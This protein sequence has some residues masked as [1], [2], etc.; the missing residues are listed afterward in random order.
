MAKFE[1]FH[2]YLDIHK[3][4]IKLG[5]GLSDLIH[6]GAS[7]QVQIC[8]NLYGD[9]SEQK[10]TKIHF[11]ADPDE[12][13]QS[14]L[15]ELPDGFFELAPEIMKFFELPSTQSVSLFEARKYDGSDWWNVEFEPPPIIFESNLYMLESEIRRLMPS[16]ST[17]QL[18]VAV[19]IND[20]DKSLSKRER[21]TLLTIIAA[22]CKEIGY[23]YTK[24]AKTAVLIS[25]TT[26]EM[27]VAVGETTIENHL[28]KIPEA[29]ATRMK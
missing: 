26:A 29:L 9:E 13:A 14:D 2:E 8:V 24:A 27:G 17:D 7:R 6:A 1:V 10:R 15:A 23:D 18:Q 20:A 4:S 21:D 28:K 3:A 12:L 25:G 16:I 22:L 19:K 5:I 11:E